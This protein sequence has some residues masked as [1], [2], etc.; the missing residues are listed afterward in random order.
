MPIT[1]LPA[2][3][4]AIHY[5]SIRQPRIWLPLV[6]VSMLAVVVSGSLVFGGLILYHGWLSA[7]LVINALPNALPQW[8][9]MALL[10][11]VLVL[12][13]WIHGR[14]IAHYGH[15]PRY[16]IKWYA[17]YATADGAFFR[18]NDYVRI[19]L[20]PLVVITG[21]GVVLLPFG[22]W[23]WLNGS[24]WPSS[25]MQLAHPGTCSWLPSRCAM[26]RQRS[27]RMRKTPCASSSPGHP[28]ARQHILP[29]GHD[30]EARKYSTI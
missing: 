11:L 22:P 29:P 14:W 12:H 25:S 19:A 30:Q 26:T 1:S 28:D 20:A 9:G 4:H 27:S 23:N 5:M 17:F 15:K 7:P 13:E 24:G 6:I 8:A 2:N 10:I 16:G 18:R 3:Y 21:I